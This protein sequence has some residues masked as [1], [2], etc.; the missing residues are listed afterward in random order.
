MAQPP[1]GLTIDLRTQVIL[2]ASSQV[3]AG[4]G[5]GLHGNALLGCLSGGSAK[6]LKIVLISNN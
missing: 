4:T 3:R 5:C 2:G 6:G 1:H